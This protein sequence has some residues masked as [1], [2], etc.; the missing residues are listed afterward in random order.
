MVR[1][2]CVFLM[3]VY[4]PLNRYLLLCFFVVFAAV[5]KAQFARFNRITVDDGLTQNSII[6]MIQ[7]KKGFIWLGTYNGLN[8]YDGVKITNYNANID[9]STAIFN[10]AIRCLYADDDDNLWGGTAGGVFKMNLRTGKITNFKYDSLNKNCLSNEIVNTIAEFEPGKLYIGTNDGLNILD[11]KS[12][13][14]TVFRKMGQNSIPFLSDRIKHMV[15][16]TRG[17]IWFSHL[18]AGITEFDPA[19]GKCK[20]YSS[21]E[22]HNKIN[23]NSVRALY[24]DKK[25]YLWVS[26]WNAG[27]NVIDTKTGKIYSSQ[28]SSHII[29][30]LKHAALISAFHEDEKGNIWCA[31]AERGLVRISSDYNSITF[32]ENNKDDSETISDN[33][34]F[35]IMQDRS[36]LLWAGTWQGGVNTL[37]LRT[38]HFGYFKHES[39]KPNSLS[40]N[41][42]QC[43]GKKSETEV[44]V[45]HSGGVDIFNLEKKTFSKFP[46]DESNPN[47]LRKNSI[48]LEVY[49]DPKDSSVWFST[50]GGYPY[51]YFPKNKKY[52]NYINKGDTNSFGHHTSYTIIRDDEGKLWIAS[53][54]QG[55]YL[56]NDLKDNFTSIKSLKG[57]ENTISSNSLTK[58]LPDGTGKFWVVTIDAGVNLFDPVTRKNKQYIR[59]AEG[60]IF[61]KDGGVS[62]SYVDR[63][64]NLWLG[65]TIG[66]VV[67]EK[68]QTKAISFDTLNPIFKSVVYSITQDLSGKIWFASDKGLVCFNQKNLKFDIFQNAD[69]LQGK[70]FSLN[71]ALTLQNGKLLF[72]GNNGINVFDPNDLE[73]NTTEPK[74]VF[75]DF[76]VLNK[77]VKLPYDVAYTNEIDLTY[78][79]YFFSFDFAALD[80]TN[81]SENIYEYKLEGFNEAWVNIGNEHRVTF[82]NLDA[83]TYTLMV[84][85]CNNDG[86]W[87]KEPASLTIT[88]SPPFWKTKWFYG[89]CALLIIA[90]IYAYIKWREQKLLKEKAIL[91]SKVEERT[92]ELK[93][94]KQKV[95]EAHKEIKDSINYA[96]RIQEAILPLKESIDKYLNEYFILYRPKDIVAGDFY[97]F[98]AL[99]NENAVLIA[100]VD[101]TGHGVPGAFMSMIGNEQLSKIINEKNITQPDL[102]L[103]ELHKGIRSALKQDQSV[104]ETRDGMDIALC[105]I[106]LKESYLEYAGAM[107]PLWLVRNGELIELKADKQPIGGIDADYR[108]PFTNNRMD[109]SKGDSLY[110]F[111][112]GYADQ[113]GGER[114]KKFMVKNFEKLLIEIN[115]QSMTQQLHL[116]D[117]RMKDWRGAHEQVDDVLVIGIRI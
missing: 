40:E 42:V 58:I 21:N 89:L 55:L 105:K 101:C 61:F 64:G 92:I 88:I 44:Y 112:D 98:H 46:I 104:G 70:E 47:S 28:D 33:T 90:I 72:G 95:E 115:N 14:F 50:S 19:T 24:L 56:Y 117:D 43:F 65:T 68:G 62:G 79:D 17:H 91:E 87:C 9:D 51:R 111:T 77:S 7:D 45:G 27:A 103:N 54:L 67:L 80:Y 1:L 16:D 15:K 4:K 3:V 71:A 96:K 38:L 49:T 34:I 13:K 10:G 83:G 106:Y 100:A 23:S 107:R 74:L 36:G 116:L 5:Y 93:E 26:C 86:V 11:K 57:D 82:T 60:K 66:L 63:D 25:G 69:G 39:T 110:M 75:T 8:K 35:T 59:D 2:K 31:T 32:F 41:S 37:N 81:S 108:K 85:A 114:G 29:K 30:M 53:S 99:P 76:T 97:W 12:G 73:R 78:R 94:E 102:I 113:F 52:A 6:S 84:R 18:N 20:Y 22:G 48:V 109:T